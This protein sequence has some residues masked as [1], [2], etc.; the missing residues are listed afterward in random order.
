MYKYE[1]V[2][3][4]PVAGPV[5]FQNNPVRDTIEDHVLQGY[6]LASVIPCGTRLEIT[7][8]AEIPDGSQ[9]LWFVEI[10]TRSGA[11]SERGPVYS[12]K[13]AN[14]LREALYRADTSLVQLKIVRRWLTPLEVQEHEPGDDPRFESL[15]DAL[16]ENIHAPL[17]DEPPVF[18]EE[19]APDD[20]SPPQSSEFFVPEG[21]ADSVLNAVD[22]EILRDIERVASGV[23][24]DF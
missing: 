22:R 12:R 16:A 13:E 8:R 3:V 15:G 14:D 23:P 21:F 2:S 19:Q 18:E 1:H 10:Q 9:R 5:G 4:S 6:E 24:E 11:V 20:E 7:F 17:I